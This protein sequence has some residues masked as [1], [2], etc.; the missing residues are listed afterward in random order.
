MRESKLC[1]PF[2]FNQYRQAPQNG[3]PDSFWEWPVKMG[4][5]ASR[6][7]KGGGG[8]HI[9]AMAITLS[10]HARFSMC[11]T[12]ASFPRACPNSWQ[13]RKLPLCAIS[14]QFS[15]EGVRGV[16]INAKI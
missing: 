12:Q 5:P 15:P 14:A 2:H 13:T 6:V 7:R 9:S 16:F 3:A 1:L 11:A 4:C 10:F 8:Q